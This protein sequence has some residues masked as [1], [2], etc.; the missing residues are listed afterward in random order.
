[1]AVT[2]P[3]AAGQTPVE[4]FRRVAI[5]NRGEAAMRLIHAAREYTDDLVTIALHTAAERGAMFVRE[6]DDAV[7]FDDL[8]VVGRSGRST[9]PYLDL[10]VLHAALVAARAEAV[11]VG[12]GF[13]AERAEF[14]DLCD[15]LGI[16]FIG[17]SGDVMRL[18]GDKI[19]AKRLAESADVP[20]APW[21]GGAVATV[22]EARAAAAAVGYPLMVKAA[23]GGGGRGIRRVDH[24]SE[25]AAAVERAQAEGASSFG[26]PTVFLERVVTAARHVEV[27]IIAD[28]FGTVWAPGV[29]DCSIQRRNQ[30]VIEESRSTALSP[31]QEQ[32]LRDAAVRLALAAEYRNAG[33]VEFLFEPEDDVLAFLEVNTRLQ[34]EHPV[35]ETTAG[36]DLVQLQLHVA[37]G[38]RLDGE[39]PPAR[40][41]A[42]EARLNA[43]DPDAGFA[44]SPGRISTLVLPTGPGIRVDTGVAE[45]D[46]IAPEYDSMIAK[47]IAW[48]ADR[49][50]ARRR[51]QR[52]LGQTT[53]LV[54]GGT[55]NKSFLLDLVDRREVVEGTLD[56][57]WLDRLTAADEHRSD[58]HAEVAL[59]VAAIDVHESECDLDR[60]RFLSSA[61]RGRPE[62]DAE[63]GH[64]VELR[65]GDQEYRVHVAT[66]DLDGWYRLTLDGVVA[67]VVVERV[68]RQPRPHHHRNPEPSLRVAGV[69][70]RA[71]GRGR[72]R[73]PPALPGR[74]RPA[75]RSGGLARGLGG[76]GGG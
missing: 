56:T 54:D 72:R 2:P 38:G 36:I 66:G 27:Q 52:A 8:P 64:E 9:S 63:I 19:A 45:G 68:G 30:K 33:T 70:R 69:P 16:T 14:A 26:D 59:A 74:R 1:M 23:A 18:L 17:P 67:D 6:A 47:I 57:G 21:S 24:E 39:C 55:T 71:P 31:A 61:A 29:R 22:D 62:A 42:F 5:V 3:R 28:D 40:G 20:M 75:P 48:G 12:W 37:M 44:P 11:W 4:R 46:V 65:W 43:E 49:D 58:R 73:L 32:R 34:V 76:G 13:V 53:V 25:L 35:T 60:V 50:A 41:H 10:E 51:L 7:C 15:A